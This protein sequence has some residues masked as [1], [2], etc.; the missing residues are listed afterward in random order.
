MANLIH[1]EMAASQVGPYAEP[2]I[3]RTLD[4]SGQAEFLEVIDQKSRGWR[5][6]CIVG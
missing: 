4:E 3:H 1:H 2:D 5:S 6:R